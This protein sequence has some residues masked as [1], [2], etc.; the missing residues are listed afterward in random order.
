MVVQYTI[1]REEL[2]GRPVPL[3]PTNI[4]NGP[5]LSHLDNLSKQKS[6]QQAIKD[7]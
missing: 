3:K 4:S 6:L 1:Q 5:V 7:Y 2:I